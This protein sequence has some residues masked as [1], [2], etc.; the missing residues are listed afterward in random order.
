MPLVGNGFAHSFLF[1]S[2]FFC[3][4]FLD[5]L[6]PTFR[7][8]INALILPES[9]SF[10]LLSLVGNCFVYGFLLGSF[11]FCTNSLDLLG[12]SAFHSVDSLVLLEAKPFPLLPLV[13]NSLVYGLP[14]GSLFVRSNLLDLVSRSS[15]QLVNSLVLSLSQVF[16]LLPLVRN[17]C[18]H[19]FS[20]VNLCPDKL[21]GLFVSK[22]WRS[23]GD[24]EESLHQSSCKIF[25]FKGQIGIPGCKRVASRGLHA[26]QNVPKNV[27]HVPFVDIFREQSRELFIQH[28]PQLVYRHAFLRKGHLTLVLLP[29]IAIP[30]FNV[31]PNIR[32][33]IHGVVFQDGLQV[34]VFLGLVYHLGVLDDFVG[35]L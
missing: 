8:H 29:E 7:D 16:S 15:L 2:F 24:R 10:S 12:P 23:L 11:F 34:R 1:G 17:C 32:V 21:C 22:G 30:F 4:N 20:R 14:F 25:L 35:N 13:S 19:S 9:Q 31:A 26:V 3:P 28:L 18:I 6:G 27:Q 33:N 5:L